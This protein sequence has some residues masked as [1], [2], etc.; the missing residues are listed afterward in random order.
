MC[1]CARARVSLRPVLR[2]CFLLFCSVFFCFVFLFYR[3]GSQPGYS[4]S[5]RPMD[6]V[7]GSGRHPKQKLPLIN[8]RD[9]RHGYGGHRRRLIRLER[10]SRKKKQKKNLRS[11]T[12]HFFDEEP[13][14]LRATCR[15]SSSLQFSLETTHS[16]QHDSCAVVDRTSENALRGTIFFKFSLHALNNSFENGSTAE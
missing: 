13:L 8:R 14:R 7:S 5:G 15:R 4:L 11:P 2:V 9:K 12:A 6:D 1:V 3:D 10:R 16:R